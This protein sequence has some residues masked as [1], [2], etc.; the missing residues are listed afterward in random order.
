MKLQFVWISHHGSKLES[1][2]NHHFSQISVFW[3]IARQRR[4][5]C[6]NFK[7]TLQIPALANLAHNGLASNV[8]SLLSW[9]FRSYHV[10]K[11]ICFNCLIPPPN[12][13]RA[14]H[15]F[16][17][18]TFKCMICSSIY[19]PGLSRLWK[20]YFQTYDLFFQWFPGLSRL[21]K[22]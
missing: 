7:P 14:Y 19:F 15:V 22:H 10:F 2:K 16:G 17:R 8:W 6:S 5:A 12:Y 9:I 21:W 4:G 20:N 11:N 18:T 13:F 1:G 3:L